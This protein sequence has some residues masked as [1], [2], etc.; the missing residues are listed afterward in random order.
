VFGLGTMQLVVCGGALALLAWAANISTIGAII[1]GVALA[2]TSTAF[3]L[4]ALAERNELNSE[5]GR[6]VFAVLL[7]Q[8]LS[9][10]PI[11]TLVTLLGAG[12]VVAGGA[13]APTA[14]G[15]PALLAVVATVLLGRPLL[16]VLFNYASKFGSHEIF[17]A[18]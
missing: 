10:I 11:L 3:A 16:S 9:V 4:P 5:H 2:M 18:S 14:P 7:F 15:W 13:H 6:G 1:V 8:D 12:A 17:T